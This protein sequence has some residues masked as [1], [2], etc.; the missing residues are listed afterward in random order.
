MGAELLYESLRSVR[1]E[2]GDG[3]RYRAALFVQDDWTILDAP[4]LV[5][6]PGIRLDLD[7]RFGVYVTPKIALRFDPSEELVLRASVGAGYRAPVFKEQLLLFENPSAGYV[8]EGNPELSPER[9]VSFNLGAELRP[10]ERLRVSL[11]LYRN[12]IDDL[13]DFATV[14]AGGAGVATRFRYVNVASAHTQGVELSAKLGP[15]EGFTFELGYVLTDSEDEDTGLPLEGRALH[16]GTAT[17]AYRASSVGFDANIRAVIVG[18]R[19][20]YVDTDGDGE[21]A[22]VDAPAYG[23]IDARIGQQI[24]DHLSVFVGAE[25]L[26]D[27]GDP[28]YLNIQPRTVYAGLSGRL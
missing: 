27:A 11:N 2:D 18:A 5:A 7:S 15:V 22:T 20:F 6:V 23:T 4:V 10:L 14:D 28:R 19:P 9:S 8:V 17:A 21:S 12:D 24:G 26:L 3:E 13:I 25:N 1:L 16:A